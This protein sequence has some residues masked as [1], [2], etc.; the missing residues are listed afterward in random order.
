MDKATVVVVD[1]NFVRIADAVLASRSKSSLTAGCSSRYVPRIRLLLVDC[2]RKGDGNDHHAPPKNAGG[3][4]VDEMWRLWWTKVHPSFDIYLV[5]WRP[6]EQ[7]WRRQPG[8]Q[9]LLGWWCLC[10]TQ[11]HGGLQPLL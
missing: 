7:L 6:H 11:Q 8:G 2:D 4:R 3:G 10:E 9:A 5:S 1:N